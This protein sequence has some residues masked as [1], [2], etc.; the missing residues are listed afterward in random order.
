MAAKRLILIGSC[1]LLILMSGVSQAQSD[2]APPIQL[3]TNLAGSVG[4]PFEYYNGH[5]FVTLTVNGRLGMSFL[6]DTGTS[7]NILNITTSQR[8][9][10]KPESIRKEKDLGLGDGKVAMAAAKNV[11]VKMGSATVA[12]VLALVD[13]RGLEQVNGHRIDGILGFPVLEHFIVELNFEN[14]MLT[15]WPSRRYRYHGDGEVL[16]LD[17]KKYPATIPVI[18]G[19]LNNSRHD[20]MVEVD[21]GND[22]T[23]LLY[24]RFAR[25]AHL[26]QDTSKP[27][28]EQVYGIGGYVPI[29][30]ATLRFMA[31]GHTAVSPLTVM[32]MQTSP[33]L[34]A[35]HNLGGAVGMGVLAKYRRV[36]FDIPQ[37]RIILEHFPLPSN[38]EIGQLS[39]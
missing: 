1:V 19:T 37:R 16:T 3:S 17:K 33:A 21:T 24:S 18:L 15:L 31:L 12:N 28:D 25:Q 11:D 8:L 13:L 23:L 4:V 39:R 14:Q 2:V 6:F 36:I 29:Q 5:I 30:I 9:G 20:A 34:A 27:Q 10:L 32:F 7:A 22:T 26:L 35:K 38:S